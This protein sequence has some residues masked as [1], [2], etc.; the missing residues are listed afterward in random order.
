MITF[1]V[2][3]VAGVLSLGAVLYVLIGYLS[4][5]FRS[6]FGKGLWL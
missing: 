3:F 4:D 5:N 2:G 6:P 1:A